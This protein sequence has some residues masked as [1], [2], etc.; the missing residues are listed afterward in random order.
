LPSRAAALTTSDISTRRLATGE[1]AGSRRHTFQLASEAPQSLFHRR[2]GVASRCAAPTASQLA[3]GLIGGTSLIA[4]PADH[5]RE[6]TNLPIH[7]PH[8][9]SRRGLATR[10]CRFPLA[11]SAL[12]SHAID[13][14]CPREA[15][16][17]LRAQPSHRHGRRKRAQAGLQ[18]PL[19]RRPGAK[20]CRGGAWRRLRG[21]VR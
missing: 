7:P 11:C 15:M 1:P 2:L 12:P 10:A 18:L 16:N 6:T 20:G 5:S 4:R 19:R 9:I 14:R 3:S 13:P 17:V 21:I 8:P